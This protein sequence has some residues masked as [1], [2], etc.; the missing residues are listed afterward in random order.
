MVLETVSIVEF[1]A[2]LYYFYRECVLLFGG[3]EALC[4]HHVSIQE[5]PQDAAG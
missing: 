4:A 5:N 1:R 2:L 3:S